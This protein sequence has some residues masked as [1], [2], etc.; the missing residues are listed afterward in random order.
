MRLNSRMVAV[1]HAAIANTFG[2]T[3]RISPMVSTEYSEGADATRP[4]IEIRAVVALTPDVEAIGGARQGSK[5]N[6]TTRFATR[7]ASL[8][9]SAAAYAGLGYD[10]QRGDRVYLIERAAEPPYVLS[11]E[12]TKTDRDDVHIHLVREGQQ[13]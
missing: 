9:L 7:S 8:W 13:E 6:S 1:A 2:E 3:V 11:R 10:V 5:I 12:P 4:V